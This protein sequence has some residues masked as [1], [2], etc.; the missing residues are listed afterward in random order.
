[1]SYLVLAR[2]YRPQSFSDLVGQEHVSQTLTNAINSGRIHHAFLFTGARGVGKTSAARI[3]AKALNCEEGLSPHPCNRCAS[4]L[5]IAAG[6]GLDVFE[7]DGASNT[8]VD[9]IRELRENI[10]YLPSRSRFKIFIIDEVHM[11][12]INAFNALLKT[13]EEPP[14]HAKFIFA[15]TE[16][17]KIPVTILSRCQ[18]FDFRKIPLAS[19]T[20][21]LREIAA[22]ENIGISDRSLALVAR[23]GEGSMR[24]ALSTFD[25]VIAFCGGQVTDEAVQGLLGLVDRR[26][27][28]DAVEGILARDS[29]RVLDAVR[30]VDDLGHSFRQFCQELVEVFRALVLLKVVDEPEGL[31]DV[32]PDEIGL[33]HGLAE[34]CGAEDLQRI[35]TVLMR[36]EAD[37]AGSSFPRLT[38]EMILV[39]LTYLPPARDVSA[40]LRKIE[41]L[42]RRLGRSGGSLPVSVS[43]GLPSDR[44]EPA[45]SKKK[46]SEPVSNDQTGSLEPGKQGGDRPQ[47]EELVRHVRQVRPRIGTMLE[48]GRLIRFEP[49]ELELGFAA[50]SFH[51]E[52]MKDAETRTVF[53]EL[54]NE[55]CKQPI[56]L[57]IVAVNGDQEGAIPPSLIEERQSRATD[58]RQKLEE[59]ARS[60]PMVR[61]VGEIF[62]GEIVEIRPLDADS[63]AGVD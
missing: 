39:R 42:E 12:S 24:D 15:T 59:E 18:R 53:Q 46:S 45:V 14:E 2:K 60:H 1:M 44:I 57:K 62:G 25:Q 41:D 22:E 19:V 54:A 16:P 36:A 4:C 47:W 55:F 5:E 7:I 31:L 23:R 34:G 29:R 35:M 11:L 40:L 28:F 52:Q 37:L 38:L 49:P 10:R 17:H 3:F 26:L 56:S 51:L 30:R 58:R 8:G 48:H 33:L 6:Q 32:A 13:L 63:Q 43:D 20:L 21:R 9:D 61:A 50:G 27:L